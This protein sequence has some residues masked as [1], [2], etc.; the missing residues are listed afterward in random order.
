MYPTM[1]RRVEH[2]TRKCQGCGLTVMAKGDW[3]GW[4]GVDM[5]QGQMQWFCD[6]TPC[7]QLRDESIVR[8][9]NEM[10]A[11]QQA[12]RAESAEIARLKAENE[13]LR[14]KLAGDVP[15]TKAP[16]LVLDA[17]PAA[18]E[19]GRQTLAESGTETH[20]LGPSGALC[21]AEGGP[22]LEPGAFTWDR[23]PCPTCLAAWNKRRE[24]PPQAAPAAEPQQPPPSAASALY[25]ERPAPR[26]VADEPPKFSPEL[27]D[28]LVSDP[29]AYKGELILVPP[30]A[31][32]ELDLA[33]IDPE[34]LRSGIGALFGG[35]FSVATIQRARREGQ[36]AGIVF[37]LKAEP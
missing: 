16:D 12:Q 19:P 23:E 10:A 30:S 15:T 28:R 1:G 6:K 5:G 34:S 32:P 7:R 9:Q 3:Q 13:E 11:E 4:K 22:A 18:P 37:T 29:S 8:R 35:R 36:F 17:Q 20:I 2:E 26:A 14:R 27:I 33:A 21:G 24:Q 25:G 31:Y